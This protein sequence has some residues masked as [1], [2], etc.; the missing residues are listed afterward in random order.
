[1]PQLGLCSALR[2]WDSVLIHYSWPG[3]QQALWATMD[4][5]RVAQ[6]APRLFWQ[7]LAVCSRSLSQGRLCMQLLPRAP[8]DMPPMAQHSG[9]GARAVLPTYTGHLAQVSLE[10]QVLCAEGTEGTRLTLLLTQESRTF[11]TA[12]PG[13]RHG[14]QRPGG[15]SGFLR[16]LTWLSKGPAQ[17]YA[18]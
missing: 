2:W 8:R 14:A 15:C 10:R 16:H 1:M 9:H 6:D 17:S 18:H 7:L 5:A 12:M 3:R 11:S 13:P 4:K